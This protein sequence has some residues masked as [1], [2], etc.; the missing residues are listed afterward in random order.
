[1]ATWCIVIGLAITHNS[2]N[3]F[4]RVVLL[5]VLLWQLYCSLASRLLWRLLKAC[6]VI[7][8]ARPVTITPYSIETESCLWEYTLQM[9][10]YC[11]GAMC[12]IYIHQQQRV[13]WITFIISLK[14]D[15]LLG[16]L[17]S[18]KHHCRCTPPSWWAPGLDQDSFKSPL[19]LF[20]FDSSVAFS[21]FSCMPL[22]ERVDLQGF[23]NNAWNT[24]NA[25]AVF[26]PCIIISLKLDRSCSSCNPNLIFWNNQ[27]KNS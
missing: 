15:A 11:T 22:R 17:G 18:S 24:W 26:S 16:D 21:C 6:S 13:K 5:M 7:T 10:S 4:F 14:C 23:Q 8:A 2:C 20:S 9:F 19:L 25:F 12:R 27:K 1:M 3:F